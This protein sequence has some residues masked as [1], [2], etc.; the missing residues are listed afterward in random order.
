MEYL[1]IPFI[2]VC[3]LF[4][5]F[6]YTG[7]KLKPWITY[8][9][10]VIPLI[11]IFLHSTN[12]L[13]HF[14]YTSMELRSDSPS[15]IIKLEG[16]PW[17]FVH[18]IFLFLC[19]MISVINLIS[20]LKEQVLFQ[21]RMQILTMVV[22]LL[23][24]IIANFFYLN[25][26][27]P[28]GIDLGPVSMS[29]SFLFHGAALVSFQMFNVAPIA[30]NY[31]FESMKEGVIVLNHKN[32]IVDYNISM[33][34]VLPTL[35][36]HVIGQSIINVLNES[37]KLAK[38][39]INEKDCDYETCIDEKQIYYQI[40]FSP[41]LNKHTQL[42]G[43]MITFVDVTDKVIMQRKLKKLASID[44]LTQVF[45]RTYFLKKSD[46]I[47]EALRLTGGSAA[48]IMFDIDYFKKVNDTLGHEAGDLV[49]CHVAKTA[50]ESLPE[51]AIIGRYG[52]EE[53]IICLPDI[54]LDETYELANLIRFNIAKSHML[55]N[56]KEICVTSS[57][58]VSHAKIHAGDHH[59][60]IQ[61]LMRQ[62]DEALFVAKK[63][64]R[65]YVHSFTETL[66]FL[67]LRDTGSR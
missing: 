45:N 24:P 64:G 14:Y 57:F 33:K 53:F 1:A 40:R 21:F 50:K 32:A 51:Q 65:N 31:V 25:D 28:Y 15:P 6:D 49:L 30:R 56:K 35:H 8:F 36:K 47:F 16:G 39:I 38:M 61:T 4:M 26:M 9:I 2:P 54:S 41:I 55:H 11:T 46:S 18:S 17:F 23:L 19:I 37:P 5:S 52:G 22:G 10:L 34:S 13:H 43:K 62:A 12:D 59:P 67:E 42:I 58:G 7:Q 48:I 20:Q 66:P 3:L 44:G 60:T 29:L 27:S 63:N